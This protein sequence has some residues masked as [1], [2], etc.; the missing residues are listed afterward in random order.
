MMLIEPASKVSV[1][2]T[3]VMFTRSRTPDNDTD[4]PTVLVAVLLIPIT[5]K[6][7]QTFPV[8]LFII[9][10]P[11]RLFE[12]TSYAARF[13]KNPLVEFEVV[14]PA[15]I[16]EEDAVYPDEVT[17]PDPICTNTELVPLVDTPLNTTVTRFA[18]D[19]TPV[20]NIDVPEVE[21]CAVPCT[22]LLDTP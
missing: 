11:L 13:I 4:P 21:F 18:Q 8:T 20:N 19:G 2:L 6:Q 10:F 14:T 3:V 12:A 16:A 15:A 7:D 1:P 5:P 17:D 22:R 9:K